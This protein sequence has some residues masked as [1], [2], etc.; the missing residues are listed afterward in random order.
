VPATYAILAGGKV[1]PPT[2]AIP[3]HFAV[4][5]TLVSGD[6]REHHAVLRTIKPYPLTVPAHGRVS[7]RVPPQRVGQYA[8]DVDG[9]RRATLVIGA[10]PGP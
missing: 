5:L 3:A 8:L 7:V 1:Q 4:Q 6:G 9:A 10:Q 2:I